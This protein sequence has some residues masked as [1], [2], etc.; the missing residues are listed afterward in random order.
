MNLQVIF[1][2]TIGFL[3]GY[4]TGLVIRPRGFADGGIVPK[5]P[6]PPPVPPRKDWHDGYVI[7]SHSKLP[8]ISEDE[9][10][11]MTREQKDRL[12]LAVLNTHVVSAIGD[13][14]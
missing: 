14:Q 9:F 3:L 5:N 11:R 2:I 7:L 6:S 8:L 1:V 4:W 13:T 12:L 10:K